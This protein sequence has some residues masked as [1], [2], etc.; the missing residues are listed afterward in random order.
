M[1]ELLRGKL[2]DKDNWGWPSWQGHVYT[3]K[4]VPTVMLD[5]LAIDPCPIHL[6][7]IIYHLSFITYHLSSVTYH[8]SYITYHIS[9]YHISSITYHLS[10]NYPSSITYWSII[11]HL[12]IYHLSMTLIKEAGK[13]EWER[14]KDRCRSYCNERCISIWEG[15]WTGFLPWSPPLFTT[16]WG[17]TIGENKSVQTEDKVNHIISSRCF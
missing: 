11:Y 7:S 8:M 5:F 2:L 12:F 9:F 6:S 14:E 3:L 1:G 13:S 4:W 16:I 17:H 10:I 15:V